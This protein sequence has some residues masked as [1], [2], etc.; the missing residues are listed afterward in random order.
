VTLVAAGEPPVTSGSGSPVINSV[1][2][3]KCPE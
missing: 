1:Y 3:T 2:V